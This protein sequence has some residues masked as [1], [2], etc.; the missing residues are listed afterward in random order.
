LRRERDMQKHRE[1]I[2]GEDVKNAGIPIEDMV[3]DVPP[4]EEALVVRE[5]EGDKGANSTHGT[6][7]SE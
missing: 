6:N 5:G 2:A 7:H 4:D 1:D 3:A